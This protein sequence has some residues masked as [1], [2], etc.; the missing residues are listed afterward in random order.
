MHNEI[1]KIHYVKGE[2]RNNINDAIRFMLT[3]EIKLY[4]FVSTHADG[5]L[6]GV[7]QAAKTG[8]FRGPSQE[9]VHGGWCQVKEDLTFS[10]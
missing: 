10:A 2:N 1:Y 4:A 5:Q 8:Y 9:V 6:Q 3:K 7:C